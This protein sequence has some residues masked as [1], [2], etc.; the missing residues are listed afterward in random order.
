M[1]SEDRRTYSESGAIEHPTV[2]SAARQDRYM[3]HDAL[4][5]SLTRF[6]LG[7][8][9]LYEAFGSWALELQKCV[10]G[11]QMSF[12]EV[13]LLHCVRLRGGTTTLAEMMIFL[14]RHDI[15][16]IN[17]SLRKL[18]AQKLIVRERGSRRREV[19]YALTNL[20]RTVTDS[21]GQMRMQ[22]LVR[23]C[24][25]VHGMQA[26]TNEAAAVMERLIGIYDQASQ[27]ILNQSLIQTAS[28]LPDAAPP[29]AAPPAAAPQRTLGTRGTARERKI[30]DE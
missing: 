10:S 19:A 27:Q 11:E 24:H 25:E 5:A 18:E 20:G 9:R 23:L 28:E 26:A 1:Q 29:A 15:A 17:Y 2:G 8:M 21:Y 4:A 14:H 16:A 6:E 7:L 3:S 22:V 30:V 12:Q 13:S